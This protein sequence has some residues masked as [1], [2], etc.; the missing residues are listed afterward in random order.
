[1][2]FDRVSDPLEKHD[3]SAKHPDIVERMTEHMQQAKA[4]ARTVAK[5]FTE[6]SNLNLSAEEVE[7]LR[8]LGY[9]GKD[10]EPS[11]RRNSSGCRTAL[12]SAR[13]PS[14]SIRT[15]PRPTSLRRGMRTAT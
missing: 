7:Q 4:A 15:G 1:M 12:T 9:V 6:A 10:N 14:R 5:H 8:A 2:L 3:I 13:M 11:K